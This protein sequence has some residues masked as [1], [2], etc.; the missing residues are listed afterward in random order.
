M[1]D[2]PLGSLPRCGQNPEQVQKPTRLQ[3]GVVMLVLTRHPGEE[4]LIDGVIRLKVVS[5]KGD[6]IRL[7]IDAPP[8]VVMDRQEIHE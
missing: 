5:V 7:G 8:S 1:A 6:H 4:I 2:G 3:G